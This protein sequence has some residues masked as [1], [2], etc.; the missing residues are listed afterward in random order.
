[1][2]K[3]IPLLLVI[4]AL[5]SCEEDSL[6]PTKMSAFINGDTWKSATQVSLLQSGNLSI[7][8]TDLNGRVI[9][10][11]IHGNSK[12]TYNIVGA[13]CVCAYKS[14]LTATGNDVYAGISG[15]VTL[16]SASSTTIS[17]TF[18]FICK[19]NLT[20]TV[21]ITNGQFTNLHVTGN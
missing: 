3:L 6:L 13:Q 18:D 14:S 4:F 1:M 12:G 8:G 21:E 9:E 16:T 7:T 10:I 11:I 2:K 15:S 19:R 5:M 20:E 17:G